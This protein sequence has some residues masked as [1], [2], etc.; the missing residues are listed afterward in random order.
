MGGASHT[1]VHQTR[2]PYLY[3]ENGGVYLVYAL[4]GESGLS[5]TKLVEEIPDIN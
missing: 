5:I 3:R 1:P 2:A 4:A